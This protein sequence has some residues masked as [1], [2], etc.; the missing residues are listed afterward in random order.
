MILCL[1]AG[2]QAAAADADRRQPD[3]QNL[4]KLSLE[5][6]M[7]VDVTL[8]TRQPE[9]V[10]T[11]AAAISVIT[12]DDMRRSGVTTIADAL[13]LASGARMPSTAS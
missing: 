13:A 2:R 11:T 8:A 9:P 7:T 3:P 5:E 4:K 12:R 10:A 6:L 1:L